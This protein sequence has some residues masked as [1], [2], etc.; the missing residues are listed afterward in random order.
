MA[1][2]M[3]SSRAVGARADIIVPPTSLLV[4][5][6]PRVNGASGHI[7]FRK[8]TDCDGVGLT[9]FGKQPEVIETHDDLLIADTHSRGPIG[10]ASRSGHVKRHTILRMESRHLH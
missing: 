7:H 6:F 10:R 4:T 5:G 1:A 8:P 3:I 2:V 9:V